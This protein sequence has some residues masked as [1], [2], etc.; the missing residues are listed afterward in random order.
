MKYPTMRIHKHKWV[1]KT[2]WM[3]RTTDS[4][5]IE[6]LFDPYYEANITECKCGEW[7]YIIP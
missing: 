5:W 7:Y 4:M 6:R 2:R 3:K 1:N